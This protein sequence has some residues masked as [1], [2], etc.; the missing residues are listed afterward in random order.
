MEE[1]GAGGSNTDPVND[2]RRLCVIG[3]D[4]CNK[5][6]KETT[7]NPNAVSFQSYLEGSA[8]SLSDSSVL[9]YVLEGWEVY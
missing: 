7:Q 1:L 4:F 5:R 6:W 9:V 3:R 2:G 8:S